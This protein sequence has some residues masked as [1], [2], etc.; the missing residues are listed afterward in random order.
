MATD[1][2]Q[3]GLRPMIG[4]D[5]TNE[6]Q[7]SRTPSKGSRTMSRE[8]FGPG[9]SGGCPPKLPRIRACRFPAPGLSSHDFAT[10]AI[11]CCCVDTV[12]VSVYLPCISS[13]VHETASPSL[14]RVPQVGSP[15][16]TVLLDAATPCRPF[17][18]ASFPSLGDTTLA[19]L[20]RPQRPRTRGRGSSWSCSSGPPSGSGLWKR[21]GLPSSRGTL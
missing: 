21:Q 10:S 19:S 8:D 14:A 18:R 15:G 9:R 11:R 17:R 2:T 13:T 7:Q 1:P 16:S 6:K 3:M 12:Q 20:V 5:R 4:Y